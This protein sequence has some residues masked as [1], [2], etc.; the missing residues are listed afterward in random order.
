LHEAH[1]TASK[2]L[3]EGPTPNA[4]GNNQATDNS[5]EALSSSAHKLGDHFHFKNETAVAKDSY[6][7]EV[8]VGH[9]PNSMGSDLHTVGNDG[10]TPIQDADLF[11]PSCGANRR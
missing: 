10:G 4:G 6:V 9:R 8:H 11:G 3:H 2:N 7:S 5:G 1:L